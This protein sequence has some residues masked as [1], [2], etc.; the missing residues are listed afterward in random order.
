MTGGMGTAETTITLNGAEVTGRAPADTT[1]VRWL[2]EQA[3]AYE[4]KEG[5]NEGT[6]GTCTVLVDGRA[7]TGCTTLAVQVDG[8]AVET[9]ASLADGEELSPLQAKFWETGAAQCGFCTQGMLMSAVE[10]L[11]SGVEVTPAVVREHLHGNLCRC[12]GYQAIVDA[13]VDA[14]AEGATR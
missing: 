8:A 12:T 1:L 10:L 7:A 3:H 13:V 14:A 11:R 9:S 5:C 6:C 2:R 4:V